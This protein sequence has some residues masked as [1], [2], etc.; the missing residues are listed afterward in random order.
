[1][2]FFY[3]PDLK[4]QHFHF[5]FLSTNHILNIFTFLSHNRHQLPYSDTFNYLPNTY[6][7]GGFY[8]AL[9]RPLMG[10]DFAHWLNNWGPEKYNYPTL[11]IYLFFL[12]LPY[13]F[14]DL[15]L[16]VLIFRYYQSQKLLLFW[17]FNP[18]SLY[19]IYFQGNFDIVPTFFAFSAFYLIKKQKPF[20]AFLLMGLSISLKMY[21]LLFLPYLFFQVKR[22]NLRQFLVCF[23]GLILPFLPIIPYLFSY[24]FLQSFSSSGLSQK[25]L[26]LKINSLPIF[27]LLYLLNLGFYFIP[28]NRA[29]LTINLFSLAVIFFACVNFHPQWLVWF[30]PFYLPVFTAPKPYF[31]LAWLLLFFSLSWVLL[32]NDNYLNLGHLVVVHPLF[33]EVTNLNRI[34]TLRF[35]LSPSQIQGYFKLALG[36]IALFSLSSYATK[37]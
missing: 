18:F 1:M 31:I 9:I 36:L 5:Q 10:N 29:N 19:L 3:H 2:P 27:P 21:G 15:F 7:L 14:F 30:I 37:K 22:Y 20:F 34:L 16:A 12:K 35:H 26:E 13:L 11:P 33:A 28:K 4:S 17:L 25:I 6:F 23:L 32:I 24:D 8:Q